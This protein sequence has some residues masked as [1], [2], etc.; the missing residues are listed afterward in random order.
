MLEKI[1]PKSTTESLKDVKFSFLLLKDNFKAFFYTQVFAIFA[2][3]LTVLIYNI[4]VEIIINLLSINRNSSLDA[5]VLVLAF[6]IFLPI[7]LTCQYGLA[8]DIIISGDMHAEFKDSLKYFR[9][10]WLSYLVVIIILFIGPYQIFVL[11]ETPIFSFG[12]I[13]GYILQIFWTALFIQTFTGISHHNSLKQAFKENFRLFK[14]YPKRI[15]VSYTILYLIFNIPIKLL[16]NNTNLIDA[17]IN[18]QA[19]LALLIEMVRY[20]IYALVATRIYS[21]LDQIPGDDAQ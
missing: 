15:F 11:P 3:I 9:K 13:I 12:K 19:F 4:A 14:H 8:Y 17:V 10:S 21:F 20:P 16:T 7:F 6:W 18:D 2:V 1:E 5:A